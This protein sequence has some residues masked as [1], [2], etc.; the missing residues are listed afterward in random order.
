MYNLGNE[1][2]HSVREVVETARRV[3]GVDFA[4]EE[5]PRRDGN[6]AVLVAGSQK[7]RQELGWQPRY[8]DLEEIIR[9][10]WEWHRRHHDGYEE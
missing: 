2:G 1:Q 6:P 4:V 8:G 3:T 7:I 5:G 9:T 10:A